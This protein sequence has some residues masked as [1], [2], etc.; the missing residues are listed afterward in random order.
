MQKYEK[1]CNK[2]TII[3]DF[4]GNRKREVTVYGI[5]SISL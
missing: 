2:T 4:A 1:I 3:L 5:V